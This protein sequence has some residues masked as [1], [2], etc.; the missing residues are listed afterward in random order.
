MIFD[1]FASRI[2]LS[3]RSAD[4]LRCDGRF[5]HLHDALLADT[6]AV[7]VGTGRRSCIDRRRSRRSRNSRCGGRS[8][9]SL[10]R[11]GRRRGGCWRRSG[12][13]RISPSR[14]VSCR[15]CGGWR[16]ISRECG[17]GCWCR[18]RLRGRVFG[19]RRQL[20]RGRGNCRHTP[21]KFSGGGNRRQFRRD[22]RRWHRGRAS[23]RSDWER[24]G[25][26]AG[27]DKWW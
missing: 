15:R 21:G 14:N 8:R 19:S 3:G 24:N 6:E 5:P 26:F 9:G 4:R 2:A 18:V 23:S 1:V 22:G 12:C 27:V 10:A 13:R 7:L 20:G 16:F 25:R 17:F 11:S